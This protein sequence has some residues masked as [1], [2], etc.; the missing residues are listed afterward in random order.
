MILPAHL[1]VLRAHKGRTCRWAGEDGLTPTGV[2]LNASWRVPMVEP[3]QG[4]LSSE[5]W[6]RERAV[7]SIGFR[8]G[9]FLDF[10]WAVRHHTC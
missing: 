1:H 2:R 7:K 10:V 8:V 9:I 4:S 3:S 5:P 6:P